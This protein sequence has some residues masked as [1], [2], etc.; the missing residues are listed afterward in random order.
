M[1]SQFEDRDYVNLFVNYPE[2]YQPFLSRITRRMKKRKCTKGSV[3]LIGCGSGRE[4]KLFSQMGF[5]VYGI[6]ISRKMIKSASTS[7]PSAKYYL[8]NA[9][10]VLQREKFRKF[11]YVL[12]LSNFLGYLKINEVKKLIKLIDKNLKNDA[13]MIFSVKLLFSK[14]WSV[15][16]TFL[17]YVIDLFSARSYRWGDLYFIDKKG[18]RLLKRHWWTQNEVKSYF[19]EYQIEFDNI[20]EGI[21]FVKK[22]CT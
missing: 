7:E 6:D 20:F 1:K 3:L 18:K 9:L 11:D 10:D 21:F 16:L 14:Y 12:C 4:P 5:E 19:G 22:V 17:S 13:M 8:G 2:G 15:P